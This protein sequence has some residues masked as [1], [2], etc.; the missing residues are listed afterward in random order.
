MITQA[1]PAPMPP[2]RKLY[3]S[4]PEGDKRQLCAALTVAIAILHGVAQGYQE[5]DS[6]E[7]R[8]PHENV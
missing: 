1:K 7:R 2:V 4:L 6:G 3:D 8:P 5:T